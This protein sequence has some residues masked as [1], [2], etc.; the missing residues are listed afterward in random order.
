METPVLFRQIDPPSPG[1]VIEDESK[2]VDQSEK[3]VICRG[4]SHIITS[5]TSAVEIDGGHNH[6]FFNPAG[7]IYEIRCFSK[8]QG[9]LLNGPSSS[10]FTWFRGFTWRV[11][12]CGSCS[13]HLG[14]FFSSGSSWFFGLI[15]NKLLSQ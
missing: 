15:G 3:G 5:E 10:E 1:E 11:A 13:I 6:T 7:V 9:C 12:L 4:C 14:W 2:M 8:A